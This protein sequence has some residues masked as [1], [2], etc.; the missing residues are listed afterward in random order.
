MNPT[1][2]IEM[3][4]SEERDGSATVQIPDDGTQQFNEGGL[5]DQSEHRENSGGGSHDQDEDPDDSR[6]STPDPDPQREAIRQA[7]REERNLK[8]KLTKARQHESNHLIN[9]LK[10][11]NEQMAD[12]LAVLEKRTQGADVARLDK[13]IEDAEVRLHYAKMKIKEST[14]MADGGGLADANEAWYEARRQV[15][16]LTAMKKQATATQKDAGLPPPTDP[17][18]K[19]HADSWMS[20]NEWFDPTG[21]DTDSSIAV[22]IDE[23][24]MADGWDP[25]SADYWE[26]LDNRLTKYLPHRYNAGNDTPSSNNRRPRSVVTSSGRESNSGGSTRANEFVLSPDRVR[27]IKETGRWDN[28]A[29]RKRMIQRYYDYDRE[30]A[31]NPR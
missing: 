15:E 7:R 14:E 8:K 2:K 1:E 28:L 31:R 11:Q 4:V 13:A 19:R 10:R 16:S 24:L 26:E 27:A 3:Q 23:S 29:E 9:S 12:R 20:R 18:L 6:D 5:N 30:Q 25:T 21:R 22:K 17:R